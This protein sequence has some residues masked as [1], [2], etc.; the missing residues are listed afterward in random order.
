MKGISRIAFKFI[1]GFHFSF[2]QKNFRIFIKGTGVL[3][4]LSLAVERKFV[5]PKVKWKN[6]IKKFLNF[7]KIPRKLKTL[8]KSIIFINLNIEKKSKVIL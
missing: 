3:C 7:L 8:V 2:E 5:V 1:M 6:T 4:K